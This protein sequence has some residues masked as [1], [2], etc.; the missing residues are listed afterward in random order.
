MTFEKLPEI[1]FFKT[2]VEVEGGGIYL[3]QLQHISGPKIKLS[4]DIPDTPK[5][6][7]AVDE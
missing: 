6:E 1:N 3:L 7:S 5:P 4:Q 2:T